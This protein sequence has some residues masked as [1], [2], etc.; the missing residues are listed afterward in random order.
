MV[1]CILVHYSGKKTNLNNLGDFLPVAGKWSGVVQNRIM[2]TKSG[3]H[4]DEMVNLMNF[5][6]ISENIEKLME[7]S[8]FC[9][10]I[11]P[12]FV[13]LSKSV[14]PCECRKS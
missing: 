11:N 12:F 5:G 9:L 6:K 1:L 7:K 10:P 14:K 3:Q 8:L 4:V 2:F 13:S